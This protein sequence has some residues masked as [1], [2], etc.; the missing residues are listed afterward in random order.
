MPGL[1][2]ALTGVCAIFVGTSLSTWVFISAIVIWGFVFMTA[3]PGVFVVL[4][5][6]SKYPEERV[7]DAQALMAAGRALGPMLGGF[8][9]DTSGSTMLGIVGASLMF[10][11]AAG[12]FIIR[13][14]VKA[15][16]SDVY[17]SRIYKP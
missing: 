8:L 1:W 16:T 5:R 2:I 6:I 14:T 15:I 7:G 4:A 17:T 13:T 10:A 11:A 12:V 3:I 9:M